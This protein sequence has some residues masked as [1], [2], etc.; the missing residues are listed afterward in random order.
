M[1]ELITKQELFVRDTDG[2]IIISEQAVEKIRAVE[3]QHKEFEKQYKKLKA[4]ILS[5]MEEY[6]IKK[7]DSDELLITYVEPTER[8][9]IDNDKLW[10]E[11]KDIAFK[12]QKDIQVKSSV[13]ITVR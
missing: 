10:S 13:R 2:N 8:V 4:T 3:V 9:G 11:Y 5:G 7:F 1:K 12:C 6:G